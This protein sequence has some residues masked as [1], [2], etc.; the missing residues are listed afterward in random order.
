MGFPGGSSSEEF[1]CQSRRP[2]TCGFNPRVGKIPW[3]RAWQPTAV[4][5]PGESHGQRSLAG[6]SPWCHREW[7]IT[8][9]LNNKNDLGRPHRF[10]LL[11]HTAPRAR[12][13]VNSW[14]LGTED[15]KTHFLI[16]IL[17]KLTREMQ[18]SYLLSLGLSFFQNEVSVTL[19]THLWTSPHGRY[20]CFSLPLAPCCLLTSLLRNTSRNQNSWDGFHCLIALS[21]SLPL[22]PSFLSIE[23]LTLITVIYS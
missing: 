20:S 22:F 13:K 12:L 10:V 16:F 7:G 9:Q 11:K 5:L 14:P 4:F 23:L 18:P 6:Y 15:W 19:G 1:V 2:K 3:R 21:L 8:E 17:A